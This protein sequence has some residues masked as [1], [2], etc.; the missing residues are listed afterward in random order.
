[1]SEIYKVSITDETGQQ[2]A[3]PPFRFGP[4]LIMAACFILWGSSVLS[5]AWIATL[6]FKFG[7]RGCHG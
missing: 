5:A 1:M 4:L 3:D 2:G 6:I 7:A